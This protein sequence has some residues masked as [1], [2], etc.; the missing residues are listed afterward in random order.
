MLCLR[1]TCCALVLTLLAACQSDQDLTDPALD[2][3]LT[4]AILSAG[5]GDVESYRMPAS[6]EYAAI[7]QDP[8]NPLSAQKVALGQLLFHETAL[9]ISGQ[10]A[11]STGTFSCASCHNAAAGYQANLVQGIGEGGIGFGES[12]EG[13]T[14]AANVAVSALDVQPIR[15]PTALNVAYQELMLWNGQFGATGDNLGTES[16]WTD[17]TPKATNHLGFEGP[18]IQAIAGLKVHRLDVDDNLLD[19]YG[20]RSRF[21][22]AFP[23][24]DVAQRYTRTTAGLAIAAY[25]RTL[26]ANRAPFQRWLEGQADAMTDAEKRGAI[27]FFGDGGCA[28]CHNGPSLASMS[29]HAL[30]MSDLHDNPEP[31]FGSHEGQAAHLGRGG[32]TM[33][34]ADMYAFKTPQL[35]NLDDSKFF[36]HGGSFRSI[37]DVVEYKLRG[38]AQNARVPAD[39]LSPSFGTASLDAEQVNDLVAFLSTGLRDAELI[40]YVPETLPSGACFPNA[41]VLSRSDMGCQ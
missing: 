4:A 38:E 35:Y 15:T 6:D 36:G 16:N 19:T 32:F 2:N 39:A 8:N 25:E 24:V 41:D 12:G 40:R 31:V 37:R 33:K 34:A 23:D 18:E 30:G 17:G 20:Y 14:R 22:A 5:Q 13:R 9:A 21:D 29:F 26:L 1:F 10:L 28:S 7:P 27:A 3:D 11:E